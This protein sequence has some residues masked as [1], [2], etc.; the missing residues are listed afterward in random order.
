MLVY[1]YQTA[2]YYQ[3]KQL[4]HTHIQHHSNISTQ[5]HTNKTDN[6]TH[7]LQI[8][9]N[10]TT[11][12]HAELKHTTPPDISWHHY[13]W[14]SI[15]REHYETQQDITKYIIAPTFKNPYSQKDV[16]AHST[17]WYSYT[18]DHRGTLISNVINKYNH[19]K[20]RHAY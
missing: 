18:D 10:G 16:N 4:S 6:N 13:R 5:Q 3:H 8:N 14:L 1:V 15:Y 19:I 7:V 11:N 12:K 2:A 17:I 9:I 20:H